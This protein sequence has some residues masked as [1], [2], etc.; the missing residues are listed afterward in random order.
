MKNFLLVRTDLKCGWCLNWIARCLQ[1]SVFLPLCIYVMGMM[2]S[3]V[4]PALAWLLFQAVNSLT[5]QVP[6][7]L[8]PDPARIITLVPWVP[9]QMYLSL[10]SIT[11]VMLW[12]LSCFQWSNKSTRGSK[13]KCV[14]QKESS[15]YTLPIKTF[16]Y[17]PINCKNKNQT[18]LSGLSRDSRAGPNSNFFIEC[19]LDAISCARS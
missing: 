16:Q 4:L 9:F 6:E 3:S 14:F 10:L 13:G 2:L 12:Q 7:R 18:S 15:N 19:H 11:A 5:R 8:L 17:F 1:P